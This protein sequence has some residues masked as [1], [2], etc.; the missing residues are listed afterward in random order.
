MPEEQRRYADN[1]RRRKG[2]C[3]RRRSSLSDDPL[4]RVRARTENEQIFVRSSSFPPTLD[5]AFLMLTLI[6]C[7]HRDI[8]NSS[9]LSICMLFSR[10]P[11]YAPRV[12]SVVSAE[13]KPRTEAAKCCDVFDLS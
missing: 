4:T 11:Q 13:N 10:K 8:T 9:L 12:T 3:E 7:V 6:F 5:E 1:E 2:G